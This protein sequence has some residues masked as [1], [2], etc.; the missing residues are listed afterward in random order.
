MRPLADADRI[1]LLLESLARQTTQPARLYLVGGATAVLFG[2]RDSTIDVDLELVPDSDELLRAIQAAKRSLDVNVE[3]A[4]PHHFIPALPGW[5]ERSLFVEQL[6]KLSVLHYDPYS[7]LLS[8]LERGHAKDL[9]DARAMVAAGL[10]E[11][12]R[13][14]DLFE[15]IEPALFR[16]P[17]VDPPTFRRAVERF[18]SG[19]AATPPTNG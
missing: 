1:R 6:G 13:L 11:L 18:V 14:S 12:Q 9:L 3:L 7:Q 15:V 16:Y 10:V 19:L 8:K 2:W 17:A 4:A 5:E